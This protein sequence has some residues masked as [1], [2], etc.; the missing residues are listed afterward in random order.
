MI[1]VMTDESNA[2]VIFSLIKKL[3]VL[4]KTNNSVLLAVSFLVFE[5]NEKCKYVSV[6][7]CDDWTQ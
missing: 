1:I 2:F 7:C 6:G 4:E 5:L 3:F